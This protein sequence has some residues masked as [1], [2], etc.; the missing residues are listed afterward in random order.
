MPSVVFSGEPLFELLK[1]ESKMLTLH[2]SC[3]YDWF[4]CLLACVFIVAHIAQ[5]YLEHFYTM[6]GKLLKLLYFL[7][8]YPLFCIFAFLRGNSLVKGEVLFLPSFGLDEFTC[9]EGGRD[10]EIFS[11][12]TRGEILCIS[13]LCCSHHQRWTFFLWEYFHKGRHSNGGR[14]WILELLLVVLSC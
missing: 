8:Y 13:G 10:F 12:L 14:L 4:E 1:T 9:Q 7:H 2:I 6:T 3:T 11:L 5:H